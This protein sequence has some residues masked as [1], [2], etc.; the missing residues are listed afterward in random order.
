MIY[1]RGLDFRH[2]KVI[3]DLFL[4]LRRFVDGYIFGSLMIFW[5]YLRLVQFGQW[6]CDYIQVLGFSL[7]SGLLHYLLAVKSSYCFSW[8]SLLLEKG[9]GWDRCKIQC[10]TTGFRT[11]T[12]VRDWTPISCTILSFHF[13]IFF[14]HSP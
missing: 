8:S 2:S 5:H 9:T 4:N 12:R 7:G 3:S 13:I 11:F 1:G 6:F 14:S 10:R